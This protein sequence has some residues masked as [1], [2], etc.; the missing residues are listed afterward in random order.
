MLLDEADSR[1]QNP[2]AYFDCI[3]QTNNSINFR[4]PEFIKKIFDY[5]QTKFNRFWTNSL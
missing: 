4:F 3:W 5:N 2:S 1:Q